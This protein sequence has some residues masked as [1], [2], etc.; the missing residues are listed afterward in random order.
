MSKNYISPSMLP[1]E[2]IAKYLELICGFGKKSDAAIDTN[3]VAGVLSNL[4]AIAATNSAGEL[5]EDR[6]TVKNALKL[7]GV[8]ADK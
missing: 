8:S 4:I 6:S 2:E 3:N 5:I 7:G 1:M